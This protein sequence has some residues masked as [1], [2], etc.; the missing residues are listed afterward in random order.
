MLKRVLKKKLNLTMHSFKIEIVLAIGLL[1][2]SACKAQLET[3]KVNTGDSIEHVE[4]PPADQVFASIERT[5]CYGTCP[6][7][8]LTIYQ[9]GLVIFQGRHLWNDDDSVDSSRMGLFNGSMSEQ[10]MLKIGAKATELG[11]FQF[12]DIYSS[13]GITDLPTT[14]TFI[15]LN[16]IPKTVVNENY[17]VPRPVFEFEYFIDGFL[18]SIALS[19]FSVNN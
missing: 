10:D 1:L 15:N 19:R 13:S 16:G 2:F 11:F 5:A 3:S 8:K 9:N 6:V 12:E 7:Y 17:N 14:T 4:I 18:E